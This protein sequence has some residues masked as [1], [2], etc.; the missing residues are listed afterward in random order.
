MNIHSYPTEPTSVDA[1]ASWPATHHKFEPEHILALQAA[2]ATNR[3]LL[4]KGETGTGKSQLAHAAAFV[5][6]RAFLPMVVNGTTEACDFHWKFDAIARLADAHVTAGLAEPEKGGDAEKNKRSKL[7][8]QHYVQPGALWWAHNWR[9]AKEQQE[10]CRHGSAFMPHTPVGWAQD[11]GLVLLIDEIDKAEPDVPNGLLEALANG[12]FDVPL[13]GCT[14]QQDEQCAKPLI[15]IT[16][17]DE[18]ELPPAFLRRCLVL[19]M[20][21]PDTDA[22]LQQYL[23]ERGKMHFPGLESA[24]LAAADMLVRDRKAA[25]GQHRYQPGMAEY[26]DLL[27]AV[28]ELQPPDQV[29]LL[30]ELKNFYFEK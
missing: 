6:G 5:T 19:T 26:L 8:I 14:V 29:K 20:K 25:A 28:A 11:K 22:G 2:Q 30:G 7:H 21:L 18:R 27:R 17:N 15:I 4:I 3:P 24:W 9:T 1:M 16:T 12:A 23:V 10:K 13:L